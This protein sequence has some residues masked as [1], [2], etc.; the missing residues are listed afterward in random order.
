MK[1]KC[2]VCKIEVTNPVGWSVFSIPRG[3]EEANVCPDCCEAIERAAQ[4][5]GI[6]VV[7][8][9]DTSDKN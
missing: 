5:K 9:V 6:L 4:K 3:N 7:A 2:D 1:E 8:K